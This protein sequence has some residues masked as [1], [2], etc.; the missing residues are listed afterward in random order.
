MSTDI[1]PSKGQIS[2]T[3]P[4]GESFG[5]QLG[6]L[7]KKVEINFA[8]PLAGDNLLGLVNNLASNAINKSKR[9]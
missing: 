7:G 6:N 2:K 3:I 8:I 1:K 9:K 4:S 5:S